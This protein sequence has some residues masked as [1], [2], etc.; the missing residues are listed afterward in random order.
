[1]VPEQKSIHGVYYDQVR[2]DGGSKH[3]KL[4]LEGDREIEGVFYGSLL[5]ASI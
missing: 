4:V 1:M 5:P 2:S 3:G